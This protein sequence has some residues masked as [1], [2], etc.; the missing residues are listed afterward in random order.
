MKSIL[1]NRTLNAD[2][3]DSSF[4]DGSI[5]ERRLE[6]KID[7]DLYDSF[8]ASDPPGWTLGVDREGLSHY[9]NEF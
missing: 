2:S 1:D 6:E 5:L 3:I 9:R 8:P 7:R 4:R